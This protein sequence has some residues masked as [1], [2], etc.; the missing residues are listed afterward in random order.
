LVGHSIGGLYV[1]K[2]A[3]KYPSE[4]VGM[5]LVDAAH[6]D[7]LKR[8]PE[9]AAESKSY[10]RLSASFPWLARIGLFRFYFATGG[11]LDMGDLP[12]EQ[13]AL[14]KAVWSSPAYFT[15][16]RA[17]MIAAPSIYADAGTLGGLGDLPLVV[18]SAGTNQPPFWAGLQDELATL[19]ANNR[20]ITD[21]QATHQSLSFKA[22]DAMI[23]SQN[24][25]AVVK[26]VVSGQPLPP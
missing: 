9:L 24:I 21:T 22:T 2:F 10:L 3:A 16:Q 18:V 7:Q 25:L 4:V 13:L 17:E 12:P 14:A 5:V 26:A 15:S 1:R 8:Y 23:T 11:V 19:S 6:P 20:H